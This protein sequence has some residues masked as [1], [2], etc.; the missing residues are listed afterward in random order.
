MKFCIVLCL[1]TV[2]LSA[3]LALEEEWYK[4]KQQ[5]GKAYSD[6]VEE[7]V[8]RAV[9]FRTFHH[10]Q[11]HNEGSHPYK[12]GLNKFADI[13]SCHRPSYTFCVKVDVCASPL[14]LD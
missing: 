13:V 2:A 5:H 9:W 11:E 12:L 6:D 1:A 14:Y 4:W 10:I 7:S 8:R 3:P